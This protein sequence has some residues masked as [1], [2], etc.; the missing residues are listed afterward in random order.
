M[1]TNQTKADSKAYLI[2]II[3]VMSL[4]S[5]THAALRSK[6]LVRMWASSP[7]MPWALLQHNIVA[8]GSA[9]PLDCGLSLQVWIQSFITYVPPATTAG[10]EHSRSSVIFFLILFLFLSLFCFLRPHP[11]H[12]EVPRLEAESEL[13]LRPQ[14]Q[15]CQ[16]LNPLREAR[17]QTRIL[18]DTRQVCNPLSHNGNAYC[19][20][21]EQNR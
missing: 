14:L 19:G 18:M 6:W 13:C 15:Q 8:S 4:A 3:L 5:E 21:F 17:D 16:I 2:R 10:T 1:C 11:R 12:K 9:T 7:P 20:F